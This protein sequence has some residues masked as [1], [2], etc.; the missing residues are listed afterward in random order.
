MY[1]E[2]T[3]KKNLHHD[4]AIEMIL[5]GKCGAFNPVLLKVLQFSSDRIRAA[6]RQKSL[7]VNS[8]KD[9]ERIMRE[10]VSRS[11]ISVS[12]R[13]LDLLDREREKY[14]FIASNSRDILFEVY[15]SPAMISFLGDGGEKLGVGV[16][17]TD[18]ATDSKAVDCFGEET[19]KK[20][21]DLIASAT[22]ENPKA[23]L[24]CTVKINGEPCSCRIDILAQYTRV[25]DKYEFESAICKINNLD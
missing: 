17:V 12:Q 7:S 9:V 5:S 6:L 2:L 23:S 25:S 22:T 11:G 24:E 1:D 4:I 20:L 18:P 16:T 19:L 13:T 10:A 21:F 14:L 8:H 15:L 3:Y